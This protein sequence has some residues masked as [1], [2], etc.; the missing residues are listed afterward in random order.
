MW[1]GC[2][3]LY[4][5]AH[6][7]TSINQRPLLFDFY[8]K[9]LGAVTITEIYDGLSVNEQIKNIYIF[10]TVFLAGENKKLFIFTIFCREI[11]YFHHFWGRVNKKLYFHIF[12]GEKMKKT[13][14]F[15]GEKMK[16]YFFQT[17]LEGG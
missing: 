1:T 16:L 2:I 7:R 15:R 8:T 3:I 4:V 5:T 10:T 11:N 12:M 13:F 14:I 6:A 17:T 9:S